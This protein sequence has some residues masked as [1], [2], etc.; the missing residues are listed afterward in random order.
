MGLKYAE[1]YH[2]LTRRV[3]VAL[4]RLAD[5]RDVEAW[6]E[7]TADKIGVDGRTFKNWY[8]AKNPP[9]GPALLCLFELFGDD[10]RDEVLGIEERGS[11][12]DLSEQI[13]A[14]EALTDALRAKQATVVPL[15]RRA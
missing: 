6:Q 15:K 3:S 7:E 5:R 12:W 2:L 10:F 11:G 9:K 8:Y 13:A 4:N 14:A 1:A